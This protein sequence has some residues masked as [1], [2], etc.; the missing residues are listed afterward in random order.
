MVDAPPEHHLLPLRLLGKQTSLMDARTFD[1][2]LLRP[3]LPQP[4]VRDPLANCTDSFYDL[5]NSRTAQVD[6]LGSPSY[7]F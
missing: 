5:A 4:S 2:L 7:Y 6:A 3:P 1:L